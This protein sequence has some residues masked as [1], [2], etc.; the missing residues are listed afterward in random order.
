M[1]IDDCPLFYANGGNFSGMTILLINCG[2]WGC[3]I[4]GWGCFFRLVFGLKMGVGRF[5]GV[6]MGVDL[7][8]NGE[9]L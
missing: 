4:G 9:I 7:L 5:L 1:I 6:K 8:K 2:W 3:G